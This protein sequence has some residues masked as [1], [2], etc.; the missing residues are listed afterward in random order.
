M[1]LQKEADGHY[2]SADHFSSY[3]TLFR[4]ASLA[5]DDL[6]TCASSSS[7][8][9]ASMSPGF[10]PGSIARRHCCAPT[11]RIPCAWKNCATWVAITATYDN[12]D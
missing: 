8:L 11:G 9:S 6:S 10:R 12:L 5:I 2:Q 4:R 7:S 3:D 1:Q